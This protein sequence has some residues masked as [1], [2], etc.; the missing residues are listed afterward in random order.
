MDTDKGL[1]EKYRMRIPVLAVD[2]GGEWKE[3]PRQSPR[4]TADAL[5]KR[6]EKDIVGLLQSR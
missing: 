1:K 2:A 3:L 6:L 4:L 5:G